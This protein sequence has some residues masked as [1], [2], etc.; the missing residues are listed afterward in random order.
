MKPESQFTGVV[1]LSQ[2]EMTDINGWAFL[3][4]FLVIGG[5]A[6]AALAIYELGTAAGA[7]ASK[8]FD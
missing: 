5:A 3:S 4:T 6:A 8:I 7:L 1:E 2:N